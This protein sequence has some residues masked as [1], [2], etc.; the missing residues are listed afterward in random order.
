MTSNATEEKYTQASE[1]TNDTVDRLESG[2]RSRGFECLADRDRSHR[3]T[4][5][6]L[7]KLPN[8]LRTMI[9]K[10]VCGGEVVHVSSV[11]RKES[12]SSVLLYICRNPK[13]LTPSQEYVKHGHGAESCE[14]MFLDVDAEHRM[15]F[16]KRHETGSPYTRGKGLILACSQTFRE[17]VFIP[18]TANTF[19]FM[20]PQDIDRFWGTLSCEGKRALRSVHLYVN[21]GRVY[22]Q[23]RW[24]RLF[25]TGVLAEFNGL[26]RLSISI[27]RKHYHWTERIVMSPGPYHLFGFL[28]WYTSRLPVVQ[29]A[30][31]EIL[32]VERERLAR[33]GFEDTELEVKLA[34]L[35]CDILEKKLMGLDF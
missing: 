10:Y 21:I 34:R 28:D 16:S 25:T 26:R 20:K 23:H 2:L 4:K 19:C 18:F 24:N 3:N 22:A 13:P 35:W 6:P 7:L 12:A 15:C 9:Y 17:V 14:C 5:S 29:F 1:L 33:V 11:R 27:C 31:V 32:A 30:R 8:E